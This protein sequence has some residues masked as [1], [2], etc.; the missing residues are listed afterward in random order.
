MQHVLPEAGGENTVLDVSRSV[1]EVVQ[2]VKTGLLD[3]ERSRKM[4]RCCSLWYRCGCFL[5]WRI[6]RSSNRTYETRMITLVLRLWHYCSCVETA[7]SND[8]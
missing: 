1:P 5:R 2:S 7:R 4:I 8:S 6:D 3:H